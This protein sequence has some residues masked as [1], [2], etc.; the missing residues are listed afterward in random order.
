MWLKAA[1]AP[2]P[3]SVSKLDGDAQLTAAVLTEA[4]KASGQAIAVLVE[5]SLGTGGRIKGFKPHVHAFVG[6]LIAHEAHHRGQI[7]LA[8][9][10]GGAPLDKKTSYG[11]WEWGVR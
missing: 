2:V 3:A 8:L 6:Y 9:K 11:L 5:S 7:A 1:G 10:A 4:L